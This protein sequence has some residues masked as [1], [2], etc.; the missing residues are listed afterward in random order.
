MKQPKEDP[1]KGKTSGEKERAQSGRDFD[2]TACRILKLSLKAPKEP[3]EAKS[4]AKVLL[5]AVSSVT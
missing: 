2:P 1:K 3:K 4:A 5:F